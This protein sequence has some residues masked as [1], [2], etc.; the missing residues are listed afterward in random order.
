MNLNH[1]YIVNFTYTDDKGLETHDMWTLASDSDEKIHKIMDENQKAF[2]AIG[3]KIVKY[4][5][6]QV[7]Y[8]DNDYKVIVGK[9]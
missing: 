8:T 5:F 1:L 6:K 7:T 9:W 3:Y 2:E 4:T